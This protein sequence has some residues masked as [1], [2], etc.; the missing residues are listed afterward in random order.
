MAQAAETEKDGPLKLYLLQIN[1]PAV[2]FK[3]AEQGGVIHPDQ[4]GLD[5][6]LGML[7]LQRGKLDDISHGL[8][9]VR[10]GQADDQVSQSAWRPRRSFANQ[11]RDAFRGNIG[12]QEAGVCQGM[13]RQPQGQAGGVGHGSEILGRDAQ[14]FA[15]D[16]DI[17]EGPHFAIGLLRGPG[18][19]S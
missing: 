10:G 6:I 11:H 18:V 7:G 8:D 12:F 17:L 5:I 19:G 4:G 16:V 9:H 13:M 2:Q 3:A 1:P 14:L 15:V